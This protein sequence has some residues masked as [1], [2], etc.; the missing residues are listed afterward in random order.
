MATGM[1]T[2][3]DSRFK[4]FLID[5]LMGA[6]LKTS[7]Q[8]ANT[9][10]SVICPALPT[11]AQSRG[12]HQVVGPAKPQVMELSKALPRVGGQLKVYYPYWENWIVLS[13]RDS[14]SLFYLDVK[15]SN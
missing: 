8:T 3:A 6:Y 4:Y 11:R 7:R 15:S 9:N 1:V 10:D 2:D 13:R 5:C 12:R 14:K